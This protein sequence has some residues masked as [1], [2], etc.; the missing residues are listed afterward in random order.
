[1][2][3][4]VNDY[5]HW[6]IVI[7]SIISIIIFF[8][9]VYF[10]RGNKKPGPAETMGHVWDDDL[11]E[12]NN[13]LPTWWLNMFVISLIFGLVYLL[14]YPGLGHF[15]GLLNW[16]STGQYENEVK[17]AGEKF[18]PIY[19][20]YAAIDVRKLSQ[21]KAAMKTGERLFANYCAVGHGS[22]ARGAKG[23]PNLRDNDWLYG[24]DPEQIKISILSGRSGVMPAWGAALG[25]AGAENVTNYILSLS[26]REH[27]V[28]LA[29]S[30][31]EK[32]TVFCVACHQADG[33]GNPALGAPNLVDR[34]W[35]YGGAKQ[36][37]VES[38]KSGRNG[39]MPA[40][41]EFLGEDRVHLLS[42]YV[43]SLSQEYEQ[44]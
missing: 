17:K 35:L 39:V 9:L 15:P 28:A 31:K 8:P 22:D 12:Y 20:K 38:I 14:L 19:E 30:G 41:K 29:E 3:D 13:P 36:T 44:E 2:A 7:V 6:F 23:F 34:I 5:W 43:Y 25:D 37:I 40:H 16:S 32:Y 10:N 42:A 21:N 18:D 33:S 1:M 4:F 11:E 24:G 26:G 27:N